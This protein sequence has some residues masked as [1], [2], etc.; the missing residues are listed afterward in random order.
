MVGPNVFQAVLDALVLVQTWR[1]YGWLK[2]HCRADGLT[3]AWGHVSLHVTCL[4]LTRG[5]LVAMQAQG[6][7]PR[8]DIPLCDVIDILGNADTMALFA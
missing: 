6:L 1:C 7:R 5:W 3:P 4:V 8:I 2:Y